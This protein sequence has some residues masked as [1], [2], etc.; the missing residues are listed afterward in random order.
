MV[1]WFRFHRDKDGKTGVI[2]GE[3]GGRWNNPSLVQVEV[4]ERAK[5]GEEKGW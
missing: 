3:K 1:E 2:I 5:V 4:V